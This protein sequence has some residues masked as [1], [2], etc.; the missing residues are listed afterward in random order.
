MHNTSAANFQPKWHAVCFYCGTFVWSIVAFFFPPI[1]LLHLNGVEFQTTSTEILQMYLL[2]SQLAASACLAVTHISIISSRIIPLFAWKCI[3]VV[4]THQG[5]SWS[6]TLWESL[7]ELLSFS[8]GPNTPPAFTAQIFC[9]VSCQLASCRRLGVIGKQKQAFNWSSYFISQTRF[10]IK[11]AF[12]FCTIW[13]VADPIYP[14]DV[15]SFRE[16][17]K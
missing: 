10:C 14:L 7:L 15:S 1:S 4:V 11:S 17:K 12:L 8:K 16:S 2:Q 13:K 9:L 3:Q 6:S 5:F